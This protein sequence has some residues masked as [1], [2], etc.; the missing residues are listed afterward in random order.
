MKLDLFDARQ[1]SS[2]GEYHKSLPLFIAILEDY[3]PMAAID[4]SILLNEI[5]NNYLDIK[6][7]KNTLLNYNKLMGIIQRN[8]EIKSKWSNVNLSVIYYNLGFY[9]EALQ[10]QLGEKPRF[11]ETRLS[12]SSYHNNRGLYFM[13]LDAYDSSLFH[14]KMALEILEPEKKQHEDFYALVNGNI[15]QLYMQETHYKEAI[16]LLINDIAQSKKVNNKL[17]IAINYLELAVCHNNEKQ[18]NLALSYLD[19]FIQVK[20]QKIDESLSLRFLKTK[21]DVYLNLNQKDSTIKYLNLYLS[22]NQIYERKKNYADLYAIKVAQDVFQL[23]SDIKDKKKQLELDNKKI[24]NE[25]TQK[26]TYL[27]AL[28]VFV[29][30]SF[31][32]LYLAIKLNRRRKLVETKNIEITNQNQTINKSLKDK[33]ILIKEIHHRVKNNL[34]V[35]SSL[36]KLQLNT[37]ENTQAKASLTDAHGRILSMALLHQQ[38]MIKDEQ[39]VV[40][41]SDFIITLSS[42]IE[43]SIVNPDKKVEIKFS[44]QPLFLPIDIASPVCLIVNEVLVNSIKHASDFTNAFKIEISLRKNDKNIW[45]TIQDNGPGFDYQK[46]KQKASSLGLEIIETVSDQINSQFKFENNKGSLF[47]LI[48]PA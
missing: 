47:T 39:S 22:K 41:V 37:T 3:S 7:L 1:A 11:N 21:S 24:E 45:L 44:L 42:H 4:S 40:E 14:F 16:P 34:Q 43:N 8:P 46:E 26:R 9:E 19:S 18:P 23:Q 38:L 48:I 12:K 33:E 29:F 36:L 25:R 10:Y 13:K 15:A 17:N 27:F 35:I 5:I 6:D 30:L 31:I 28:I 2:R 20:S 32:I